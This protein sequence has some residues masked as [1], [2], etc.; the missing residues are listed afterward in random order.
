MSTGR[1]WRG[2]AA[3]LIAAVSAGALAQSPDSPVEHRVGRV[4]VKRQD[5]ARGTPGESTKT[6]LKLDTFHDGPVELLRVEIPFPDE[7][8]DFG[9]S[10]FNPKEGDVKVRAG[11][12]A[13]H[14]GGAA[15]PSFVEI[16]FPTANPDEGGTGKY[17]LGLGIRMLIPL[18]PPFSD[19]RA[20]K[21]LFEAQ[22]Q[23]VNSFA[24]DPA[25]ASIN[26][27]KIELTVSDV[28]HGQYTGKA[29]L[30]PTIDWEKGG[31]TG[32]VAEVEAGLNFAHDWRTWL[33]LGRRV[34]GPS[35]IAGT[36][37]NRVE[38]GLAYTF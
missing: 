35:D 30:K 13:F 24:G 15:F 9:G 18:H 16:T 14:A 2:L 5:T 36:Y 8:D 17:Q 23:Q 20:H 1:D 12:R 27:T 19:P 21:T 33:M 37:L 29:K 7:K 22:V 26:N 10:P 3:A 28:W 11:F 38:L 25:R 4:E 32:G 6:N 34:W 31:N